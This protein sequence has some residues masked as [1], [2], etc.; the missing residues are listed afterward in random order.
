MLGVEKCGQ[1]Q[2][3][4][5]KTARRTCLKWG[6]G[7]GCPQRCRLGAVLAHGVP[8]GHPCKH[9]WLALSSGLSH[10]PSASEGESCATRHQGVPGDTRGSAAG[11]LCTGWPGRWWKQPLLMEPTTVDTFKDRLLLLVQYG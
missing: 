7:S 6:M 11:S 5:V 8:C 4:V 1:R 9:A 3:S 10:R 2:R